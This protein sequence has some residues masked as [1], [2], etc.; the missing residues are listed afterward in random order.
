[1]PADTKP[2]GANT[3]VFPVIPWLRSCAQ[4]V[5]LRWLKKENSTYLLALESSITG[6]LATFR[7]FIQEIWQ[8][9]RFYLWQGSLTFA[10]PELMVILKNSFAYNDKKWQLSVGTNS[11]KGYSMVETTQ[12]GSGMKSAVKHTTESNDLSGP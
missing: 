1:M 6:K 5:P 10:I 8:G 7:S 4:V 12:E 9:G 2:R 3:A 11:A